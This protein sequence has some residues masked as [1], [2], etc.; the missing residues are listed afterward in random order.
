[1]A[2][3][4][5]VHWVLI[6]RPEMINV[7]AVAAFLPADG[8]EEVRAVSRDDFLRTFDRFWRDGW[9]RLGPVLN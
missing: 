2:E 6:N 8:M 4:A 5:L 1:M 7:E 9:F 3:S